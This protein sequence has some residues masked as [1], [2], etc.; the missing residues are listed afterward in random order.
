[1]E[2]HAGE[3]GQQA[4]EKNEEK[5]GNEA[6]PAARAALPAIRPAQGALV[7][8]SFNLMAEFTSA[9]HREIAPLYIKEAGTG[10]LGILASQGLYRMG[11]HADG[12][13][14]LLFA[15]DPADL[16][17]AQHR[18]AQFRAK[19]APGYYLAP[20]G[21]RRIDVVA[22]RRRR[23]H[24]KWVAEAVNRHSY[25]LNDTKGEFG[26]LYRLS[27]R[28]WLSG[29][30]AY[31]LEPVREKKKENAAAAGPQLYRV[32][33][34]TTPGRAQPFG[35]IGEAQLDTRFGHILSWGKNK[36][37]A[38]MED[39]EAVIREDFARRADLVRRNRD[40]NLLGRLKNEPEASSRL[41]P[42]VQGIGPKLGRA[43][44]NGVVRFV[45]AAAEQ[46]HTIRA[47]AVVLG[48][49]RTILLSAVQFLFKGW[50]ATVGQVLLGALTPV[51]NSLKRAQALA[52][53][54]RLEDIGYSFW[55]PGRNAAGGSEA[56]YC[57]IDPEQ[58][59]LVRLL[60]YDEARVRPLEGA[61]LRTHLR[62]DLAEEYILDTLDSPTGSVAARRHI[63]GGDVLH[64]AEP[65]GL[66]IYYLVG[67]NI[68]YA[69]APDPA[70][71]Y[72]GH[73]NESVRRLMA[74]KGPVVRVSAPEG[75]GALASC[76][77]PEAAFAARLVSDMENA[78][79]VSDIPP[80]AYE[81]PLLEEFARRAEAERRDSAGLRGAV[82]SAF[83][84][85]A[86]A[87]AALRLKR[88]PETAPG[89]L[90][91][92]Q[93]A[94]KLADRGPVARP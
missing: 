18:D 14:V 90:T 43:A 44:V 74:E 59:P 85:A 46:V 53:N 49:G 75:G 8:A 21:I 80:L 71:S 22:A 25:S 11:V 64:V 34:Y 70:K 30:I 27:E 23:T 94:A 2:R 92:A 12:R 33:C 91:R 58:A 67:K 41:S 79:V 55:K 61:S 35:N 32:R 17:P 52:A 93:I 69:L 57:R 88:R 26:I 82:R 89:A 48:V 1:M 84:A 3:A 77:V 36:T 13:P 56:H 39:A 86:R 5:A 40:P 37:L 65:N 83:N 15:E 76:N 50:R 42:F 19:Y 31:T 24:K 54:S 73:M 72:P 28:M 62:P 51:M 68:A 6:S 9:G 66:E 20:A 16:A 81:L 63:G 78:P 29:A 4:P 7:P 60:G 10:L 47:Q 87:G 45:Q 38:T